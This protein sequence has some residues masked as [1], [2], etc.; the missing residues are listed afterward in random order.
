M[1]FEPSRMTIL[2]LGSEQIMKLGIQIFLRAGRVR[3]Q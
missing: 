2:G 3:I 1:S